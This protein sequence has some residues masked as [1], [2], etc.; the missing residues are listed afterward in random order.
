ML[1][2]P[3]CREFNKD[4]QHFYIGSILFTENKIIR[5]VV[6]GKVDGQILFCI[7]SEKPK[8]LFGT[9]D[10]K[11]KNVFGIRWQLRKIL[12]GSQRVKESHI[13]PQQVST[14]HMLYITLCFTCLI[15]WLPLSGDPAII[16]YKM[17]P[18]SWGQA[19]T[20]PAKWCCYPDVRLDAYAF[21]LKIEKKIFFSYDIYGFAINKKDILASDDPGLMS[22]VLVDEAGLISN[23]RLIHFKLRMNRP[24][25]QPMEVT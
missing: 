10:E 11:R 2:S 20:L 3:Y 19:K 1:F 4:I 8:I 21:C 22:D 6:G 25:C 12:F 23:H 14:P 15:L 13:K 24:S 5:S 7:R 9:R 18:L 17:A 16:F